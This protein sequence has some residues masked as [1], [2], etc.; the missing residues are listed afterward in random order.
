[1]KRSCLVAVGLLFALL[2]GNTAADPLRGPETPAEASS[3]TRAFPTLP[4]GEEPWTRRLLG[5]VT[6]ELDQAVERLGRLARGTG[7]GLKGLL[8]AGYD[9]MPRRMVLTERSG[10]EGKTPRAE[11]LQR[12]RG[13]SSDAELDE[14]LR[15]LDA[16][17]TPP[18]KNFGKRPPKA[19]D[20]APKASDEEE[21][22]REQ[23]AGKTDATGASP[24][25]ARS[26]LQ[27]LEARGELQD[28]TGA[29]TGIYSRAVAPQL[30]MAGFQEWKAE[31]EIAHSQS[32]IEPLDPSQTHRPSCLELQR[33]ETQ[34][35]E[36]QA[37]R[38]PEA[39]MPEAPMLD[40]V[41][42]SALMPDEARLLADGSL[43][44]P[45]L[46][47][48]LLDIRTLQAC[49]E[50]LPQIIRLPGR[51]ISNPAAGGVVQAAQVGRIR[52]GPGNLTDL[53]MRVRAGQSLA[54]LEPS[55]S[56]V[57]R[58]QLES[59][60][61]ELRGEI[62]E[63]ELQLARMRDFPIVPFRSGRML[64]LRLELDGLRKRR[65][66]L[67]AALDNHEVLLSPLDGVITHV[68]ARAGQLVQPGDT[69]WEISDP[70]ALQVEVALPED[71]P[72][73]AI[74]RAV[75]F[76]DAG[77]ELPLISA[78]PAPTGGQ[79][80]LVLQFELLER[81]PELRRGTAVTVL[82]EAGAS[83][84]ALLLPREGLLAQDANTFLVWEH[85]EGE[86]FVAHQVAAEVID[87]GTVA[88]RA[89]IADGARIVL[90]G[91]EGLLALR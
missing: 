51:L 91:A 50:M 47:Q 27:R 6:A 29:E 80:G 45:K 37:V 76:T 43:F 32:A 41:S 67:I 58:G 52:P 12:G 84:P 49:R 85:L 69:L 10:A 66:H 11:T 81:P 44:V 86:R 5:G 38:P 23:T 7:E 24:G 63:T 72:Q 8:D 18:I 42:L 33:K 71:F 57:E 39:P 68:G 25:S 13:T 15:R 77:D 3:I 19:L 53:G 89:G 46:A 17:Q 20:P 59:Q 62:I 75:A 64:A 22:L 78:R 87:D 61:A 83:R 88:V 21:R 1:M 34:A 90:Q 4:E 82:L 54:V 40:A 14:M 60:L 28:R 74:E 2:P 35:G 55:L 73:R 36:G 26:L 70:E 79:A 9:A 65:N 30:A 56:T 16:L 31:E 48:R